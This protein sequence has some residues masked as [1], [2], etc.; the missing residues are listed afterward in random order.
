[1]MIKTTTTPWATIVILPHSSI[2]LKLMPRS[3]WF[4]FAFRLPILV[5]PERY[6]HGQVNPDGPAV[7]G[8]RLVLP[9][10]DGPDRRGV[11]QGVHGLQDPNVL[12]RP[13]V[14]D[15]RLQDDD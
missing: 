1:M 3:F 12:D 9:L 6:G 5:Q 15:D 7:Q 2:G 11:E 14:R 10:L 8:R 13:L 4:S